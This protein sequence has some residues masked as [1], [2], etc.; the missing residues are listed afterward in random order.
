MAKSITGDSIFIPRATKLLEIV[1]RDYPARL[2][3]FRKVL[4]GKANKSMC[5]KAQCL[6]CQG[7]DTMGIRE[8]GDRCCPLWNHRPFQ[9]KRTKDKT[10]KPHG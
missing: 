1:E 2:G 8:C 3:L 10:E 9:A 5:I 6:D 4:G 7:F